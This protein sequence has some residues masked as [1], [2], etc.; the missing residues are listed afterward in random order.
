MVADFVGCQLA[1]EIDDAQKILL[2]KDDLR[3]PAAKQPIMQ[4]VPEPEPA[5]TPKTT[6]EKHYKPFTDTDAAKVNL[7]ELLTNI[8]YQLDIA[9]IYGNDVLSAL[10][11]EAKD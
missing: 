11:S 10:L 5:A 9:T 7:Q 3:R 6:P 1:F 2:T 4:N 8:R